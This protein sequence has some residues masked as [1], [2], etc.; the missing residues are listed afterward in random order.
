MA[1][2]VD[3]V[4]GMEIVPDAV[5]CANV[6]KSLNGVKNAHFYCG[7]A[8]NAEGLLA[9]VEAERGTLHPDVV[10]LDPPRKGCDKQL[11][12]FLAAREVPRIV[13]VSCGPDTLARD[14]VTLRAN[15][16]EM[17][18]VTP[19]DLFPCTGHVESVVRFERMIQ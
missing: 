14:C 16:Y 5:T 11:L 8:A 12:D 4:I 2:R 17:G 13:Y 18:E 19:V 1:E 3:E 6:N 15:G 7:D 9:P 10:I